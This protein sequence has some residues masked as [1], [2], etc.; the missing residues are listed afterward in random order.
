M[1]ELTPVTQL[2]MQGAAAANALA[3]G[4]N[5]GTDAWRKQQA[6]NALRATYGDAAGDPVANQQ[7]ATTAALQQKLPGELQQQALDNQGKAQTNQFEAAANPLRLQT[8][9]TS[10][11]QGRQN[12]NTDIAQ[13]P[14]RQQMLANQT[15]ATGQQV[16]INKQTLATG[17]QTAADA[18]TAKLQAVVKGAV[19][20]LGDALK[21]GEDPETAFNRIAP[22]AAQQAGLDPN[23]PELQAFKQHFI[24]NPQATL[25]AAS[26]H[27]QANRS[28]AQISAEANEAKA[29]NAS[30][31]KKA[32][33]PLE[34]M[35]GLTNLS[36]SADNYLSA[37]DDAIALLPKIAS[38]PAVAALK[39]QYPDSYEA[40]LARKIGQI[41]S[42]A[43]LAE[44][45]AMRQ[46]GFSFGR[47]S[48]AD[49][50]QAN[51]AATI[52]DIRLPLPELEKQF[53]QLRTAANNTRVSLRAGIN[54]ARSRLSTEEASS[55]AEAEKN[56]G[57]TPSAAPAT[58]GARSAADVLK[59]YG[60]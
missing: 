54:D 34:Q 43:T 47:V 8:L 27:I 9:G 40:L 6:Y 29:A 37:V 52:A 56:P 14:L 42:S 26:N 20:S 16:D 11:Q 41:K 10:V 1:F 60:L 5:E 25:D 55:L 51:D 30:G 46:G 53:R 23:S 33:P 48:N 2:G 15:T 21:S 58:P 7:L 22:V 18:Q 4:I 39:A 32:L 44:L 45:Q 13:A 17:A 35:R 50:K 12:L 24:A 3:T 57:G 49:L 59:Q 36:V 28:P 31:N 38:N 19:D